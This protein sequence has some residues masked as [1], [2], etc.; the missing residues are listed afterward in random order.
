M[1]LKELRI[2]HWKLSQYHAKNANSL[3]NIQEG[4]AAIQMGLSSFHL[5]AVLAI[6]DVIGGSVEKDIADAKALADLVPPYSVS[7]AKDGR[8][9][10]TRGVVSTYIEQDGAINPN[11]IRYSLMT[12]KTHNLKLNVSVFE[13]VLSGAKNSEF[14]FNDR[15][16]EVGDKLILSEWSDRM[17]ENK[18]VRF[19]ERRI[20]HIQEGF[21]IPSG[22]VVLS[23]VPM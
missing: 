15:G 22:Y 5:S 13:A 11:D 3:A 19:V 23:L 16:F 7:A 17:Y 10:I 2:W 9:M 18:P 4:Y 14:R 1:T 12:I 8:Q 21:G 6:T 20:T